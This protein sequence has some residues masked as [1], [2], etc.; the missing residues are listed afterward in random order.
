MQARSGAVKVQ[1]A[2]VALTAAN[3]VADDGPIAVQ[4]AE[5]AD[6][7]S[8]PAKAMMTGLVWSVGKNRGKRLSGAEI[9]EILNANPHV[10]GLF[11][12]RDWR[13]VEPARGT[14]DWKSLDGAVEAA[15]RKGRFYKLSFKPGT[16]T[17][18]WVYSKQG[19]GAV[20]AA[21]FETIGPN[22]NRKA[23][24]QK[25]VRIPVPWDPVFLGEFERFV[26]AAGRRY[27]SDPLCAAV[28]I[29]GANFQSAEVHLP[30]RPEDIERW[31]TLGYRE[32]LPE[33]YERYIDLFAEAFPRQQLCLHISTAVRKDDGIMENAVAYGA[34]RYP[35]RLTLQNCQ[36]NGKSNNTR[37]YS[38]ALLQ[39]Y[40]GKLHLGYQSLALIAEGERGKRMGDPQRAVA[41]F[42]RGHGEYWEL[43][44]ANGRDPA[45]C[46]WLRDEI[47]RARSQAAK[48]P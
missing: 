6:V 38:Y 30:K 17:P 29:T 27:A 11:L 26:A 43:W 48:S 44:D 5:A 35:D 31:E 19:D 24:Y 1:A 42:V 37:L 36:L 47:E 15:R 34:R 41:N 25:P 2:F 40:A 39:Q 32:K 13:E 33:A 46:E 3:V 9:E 18:D 28:A 12:H 21:V 20:G 8:V 45:M 7:R 4:G 23:T 16:G 22:P 10:S 14:F